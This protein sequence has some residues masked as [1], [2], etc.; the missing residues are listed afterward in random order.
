LSE[1][2]KPRDPDLDLGS[3]QGHINLNSMCRTSSLPYH[4]T[5]VSRSTEI[6]LFEFREMSTFGEL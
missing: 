1:V 6:W 3:G 5:V 4:V 2:Q